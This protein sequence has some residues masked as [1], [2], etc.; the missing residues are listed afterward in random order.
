MT[1]YVLIA[2]IHH[3]AAFG[4]IGVLVAELTL[5][6]TIKSDSDVFRLARV[7]GLYG[8]LAVI[9][10]AIGLVRVHFGY[11][12]S[13]FYWENPVFILK[14]TLFIAVGLLSIPPTV[15]YLRWSR[16]LKSGGV[17]PDGQEVA[18]AKRWLWAEAV[19]IAFIP[20]LAAAMARGVGL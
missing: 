20:I 5:I 12:E 11:N 10:F 17:I 19:L 6:Q 3:L 8:L 18:A 2:A 15:M 9:L 7:D 1:W 14:L 16:R 13:S 4:L